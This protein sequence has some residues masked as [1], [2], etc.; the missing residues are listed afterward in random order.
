MLDDRRVSAT[1]FGPEHGLLG[2]AQDLG[3]VQ[4]AGVV[5]VDVLD[6]GRRAQPGC[7]QAAV[8][9][10]AG[11]FG[12]LAVDEHGKALLEAQ[13]VVVGMLALFGEPSGHAG[14]LQGVQ[15]LEGGVG[16]HGLAVSFHR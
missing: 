8:H 13:G 3:A 4:A 11:P 10:P 12:E 16:Q 7:F 5:E 9:A 6:G 2:E 15:A 1:V 14:Q